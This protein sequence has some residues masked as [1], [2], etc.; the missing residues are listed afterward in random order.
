[1]A[2]RGNPELSGIAI[3]MSGTE[4]GEAV[5]S[6]RPRAHK[7]TKSRGFGGNAGENIKR[8]SGNG[9]RKVRNDSN[10]VPGIRSLV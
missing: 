5:S 1:V 4:L 2:S 10:A 3:S 6:I 7:G 8:V 9:I